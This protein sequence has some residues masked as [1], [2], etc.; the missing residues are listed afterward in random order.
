[1]SLEMSL[2]KLIVFMLQG[3][4]LSDHFISINKFGNQMYVVNLKFADQLS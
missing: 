3:L 4:N 1:M 2:V